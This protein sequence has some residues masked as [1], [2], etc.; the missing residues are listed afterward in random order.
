MAASATS[1]EPLDSA[2][3]PEY[4]GTAVRRM[5]SARE[6]AA[7]LTEAQL[8]SDWETSRRFILWAGG[9]RDL[10]SAR[11]GEGYTGHSFND[12]NHCDLT[13]M[14]GEQVHSENEG[15]VA[16]IHFSNRLGRGIEVASLPE[17]GPGG[18]WSTCMIGCN[19]EPPRDVAHLQFKSRIA[20]K[21]VWCPPD[22][23]TF[24][25]VD[26]DGKLINKVRVHFTF[27]PVV[28]FRCYSCSHLCILHITLQILHR[29]YYRELLLGIFRI[30]MSDSKTISSFVVASMLPQLIK[31]MHHSII[32][33]S[34]NIRFNVCIYIVVIAI[35]TT[36]LHL[37][38]PLASALLI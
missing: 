26:D 38:M 30:S 23:K 32:A 11:P 4:P 27:D 6:R 3:D 34:N 2:I 21:L 18:S 13:T 12:F 24:V 8:S 37:G 5:I 33:P 17:L 35:F 28:L 10:A 16:G 1:G 15:R 22:F 20:F 29:K 19:A 9:L 36:A 31:C 25:L 14:L 7:S